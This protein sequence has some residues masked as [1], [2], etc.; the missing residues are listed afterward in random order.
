MPRI[1][2]AYRHSK[3]TAQPDRLTAA[4]VWRVA[5]ETRVQVGDERFER[6]LDLDGVAKRLSELEV[7]GVRF[8]VAWD[9][10]HDVLNAAGEPVMGV[11][12]YDKA[13]PECILVSVNG[14]MLGNSETLFR[15]TIA[16]E[17]GHVVFDAPGW[18]LVPPSAPA[19]SGFT[20]SPRTRDPRELRANEFMGALLVPP[21]LLRVD[22]QRLAKRHRL[23]SSARPSTV[24]S[25]APAYDA[26]RLDRDAV[27]EV[28]FS[29][30]ES[31]GV[32]EGFLRV[33]LDRY[34]LLRTG[35]A[36]DAR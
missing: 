6:R 27:E 36:W 14:P 17:L 19:S 11:T 35:R 16:H 24:I 28:I 15:S 10:D 21:S 29:L 33:R 3:F 9:V 25:G 18:I 34:D 2:V 22:L 31:Y 20:S 5:R 1:Q 32:S 8:E 26:S 4:D 7:N 23:V 12:E 13:S 30:A